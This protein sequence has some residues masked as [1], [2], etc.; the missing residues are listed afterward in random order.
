MQD[1]LGRLLERAEAC[2]RD[3]R[4]DTISVF[5]R[6]R[7][8]YDCAVFS[9]L[10]L[11]E[12]QSMPVLYDDP[13]EALSVLGKH[14]TPLASDIG[15]LLDLCRRCDVE[16]AGDWHTLRDVD[17]TLGCECAERIKLAVSHLLE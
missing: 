16:N 11:A 5:T 14:V 8:A 1:E 4:V 2:I 15:H 9:A 12:A 3:A 6:L 7:A 17:A 10:A 13:N